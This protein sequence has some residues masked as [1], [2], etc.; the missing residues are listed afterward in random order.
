M[1]SYVSAFFTATVLVPAFAASAVL[2]ITLIVFTS[3]AFSA[4]FTFVV[5]ASMAIS[6]LI[7]ALVAFELFVQE[8][9]PYFA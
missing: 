6:A 8:L 2:I 4:F 7:F 1:L 5:F 3:M 9:L